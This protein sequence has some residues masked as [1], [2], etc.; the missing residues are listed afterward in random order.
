VKVLIGFDNHGLAGDVSAAVN[1]AGYEPV[2]V[3]TGRDMLRRLHEGSD[4]DL[5]LLDSALPDP[6]LASL[7]A[8]IR[9]D[10]YAGR[11]PIVLAA[12]G[13]YDATLRSLREQYREASHRLDLARERAESFRSRNLA[14]LSTQ[15]DEEGQRL[16]RT[17][18]DLSKRYGAESLRLED[19]LR[20]FVEHYPGIWVVPGDL[21]L[22]SAKLKPVLQERL[23]QADSPPLGESQRKEYAE[24]AMSWLGKI[25]RG[26]VAGYDLR[27][28]PGLVDTV[29]QALTTPGFSDQAVAA[30][31]DV[32]ARQPGSKEQRMLAAVLLDAR[33]ALPLRIQAADELVRHIQR[34][35]LSLTPG[36]VEALQQL[37]TANADKTLR[38]HI[39][40]VVGSLRPDARQTGE[41]L[42]A[43][44][45]TAPGDK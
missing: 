10:V 41:R 33:R 38:P 15:S 27:S 26:E 34:F 36:D 24:R 39:E 5:V 31:I 18:D 12:S 29:L 30:G 13:E 21:P 16:Q 2:V 1:R 43:Y 28:A 4:I 35:S 11:L 3:H 14:S 45:P 22:D 9:G 40:V 17:L 6:G 44:A 7:L 23:A 32:I 20:R 19:R 37:A 8:Q 25:A 42:K